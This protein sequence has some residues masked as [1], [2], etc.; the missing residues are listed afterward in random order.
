MA[1]LAV[2]PVLR[3][4]N[5]DRSMGFYVS[6]LGF[7]ESFRFGEPPRYA[8]LRNTSGADE[9]DDTHLHINL[10]TDNAGNGEIY[11]E[12]DDVDRVY[13]RVNA[14]GVAV[15]VPLQAQPYGMR[16]FSVRDPAGNFVT[17]GT[18]VGA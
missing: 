10:V 3:V 14:A 11:V 4:D 6:V 16:D 15:E 12:V 8:G 2:V 5:L 13:E 9:A 1:L 7:T 18:Q 17:V